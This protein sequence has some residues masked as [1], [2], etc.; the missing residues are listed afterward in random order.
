MSIHLAFLAAINDWLIQNP[1]PTPM[2][3]IFT[4]CLILISRTCLHIEIALAASTDDDWK[5]SPLLSD[6]YCSLTDAMIL[7]SIISGPS[8]VDSLCAFLSF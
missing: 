7:F 1:A 5:H 2:Y 4:I 6:S 8:E 3:R